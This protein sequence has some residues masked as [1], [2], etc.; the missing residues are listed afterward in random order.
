LVAERHRGALAHP[1]VRASLARHSDYLQ[2]LITATDEEVATLIRPSPA[3]REK[4]DLLPSAPGI[5]AVLSATLPAA[6]PE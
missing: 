3:W 6:L 4:E 1:T 5:G 2:G